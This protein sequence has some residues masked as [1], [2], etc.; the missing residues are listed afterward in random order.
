MVAF[1]IITSTKFIKGDTMSIS[2]KISE[3]VR[4]R[5]T[6][7]CNILI[8]TF[9]IKL[10]TAE[11][12]LDAWTFDCPEA[13]L[14][15]LI[16]RDHASKVTEPHKVKAV[17]GHKIIGAEV[18]PKTVRMYYNSYTRKRYFLVDGVL[19]RDNAWSYEPV[20][21]TAVSPLEVPISELT[22]AEVN[23]AKSKLI[24]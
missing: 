16:N 14:E 4:D 18:I 1:M 17:S 20:H 9:D 8:N 3:A 6:S 5:S 12:L 24:I 22:E 19:E 11:A 23:F 21:S 2:I 10:A 13:Y 15:F 7:A